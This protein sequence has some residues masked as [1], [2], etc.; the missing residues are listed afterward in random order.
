MDSFVPLI[1]LFNQLPLPHEQINAVELYRSPSA[2]R[3]ATF[4][5][6]LWRSDTLP[7]SPKVGLHRNAFTLASLR[8]IDDAVNDVNEGT[9]GGMK[10]L[11]KVGRLHR[12]RQLCCLVFD[13]ILDLHNT[14]Q[15]DAQQVD[16]Q[17]KLQRIQVELEKWYGRLSRLLANSKYKQS[18]LNDC[19]W[20]LFF[21]ICTMFVMLRLTVM[22]TT[23][24][25]QLADTKTDVVDDEAAIMLCSLLAIQ[26]KPRRRAQRPII[27]ILLND[28]QKSTRG[29]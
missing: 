21:I 16:L 9:P 22:L 24:W 14:E 19:A 2:P 27:R 10:R 3:F 26:F 4:S 25:A 13:C 15:K 6:L 23:S 12:L 20:D 17:E 11:L 18:D 1:P 5:D 29:Q 8:A 28:K 7:G